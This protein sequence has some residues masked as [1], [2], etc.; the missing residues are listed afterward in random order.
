VRLATLPL[1][2]A[3]LPTGVSVPFFLDDALR[4]DELAVAKRWAKMPGIELDGIHVVGEGL[5]AGRVRALPGS[6]A[7]DVSKPQAGER[8][9]APRPSAARAR[10]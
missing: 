3:V 6:D 2:Q 4:D 10:H 5:L 8:E 9:A 7:M 1:V